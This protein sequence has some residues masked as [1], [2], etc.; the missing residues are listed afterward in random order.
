[1]KCKKCGKVTVFDVLSM[2][3]IAFCLRQKEN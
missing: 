1:M 3:K 2:R